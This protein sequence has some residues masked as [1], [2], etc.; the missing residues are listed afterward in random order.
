MARHRLLLLNFGCGIS[1]LWDD[2]FASLVPFS[3]EHGIRYMLAL[4]NEVAQLV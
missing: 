1:T 3:S 4:Y 2:L